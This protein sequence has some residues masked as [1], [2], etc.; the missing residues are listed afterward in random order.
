MMCQ[1]EEKK[2]FNL[3]LPFSLKSKNIYYEN[4][5]H[6]PAY[7]KPLPSQGVPIVR[8]IPNK[9]NKYFFVF[10]ILF[11]GVFVVVFVVVFK[12]VLVEVFLIVVVV[13]III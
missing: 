13:I 12:V 1:G 9:S 7:K 2:I 11:M 4:K 5:Y 8:V 3:F 6:H 10:V